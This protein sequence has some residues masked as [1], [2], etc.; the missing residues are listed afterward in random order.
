MWQGLDFIFPPALRM[1]CKTKVHWLELTFMVEQ[2]LKPYIE[3]N[4]IES[5]RGVGHY[6]FFFSSQVDHNLYEISNQRENISWWLLAYTK[7]LNIVLLYISINITKPL[8][9]LFHYKEVHKCPKYNLA[10]H[11]YRSHKA[12]STSFSLWG[13]RRWLRSIS[14]SPP[15][16]SSRLPAD[17]RSQ[18]PETGNKMH[19]TKLWFSLLV[20]FFCFFL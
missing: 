7:V 1:R 5:T 4:W 10:S 14:G 20:S 16:L 8:L 6:L 15:G 3:F 18:G 12:V 17:W 9:R 2:I 13:S 11:Q 19:H